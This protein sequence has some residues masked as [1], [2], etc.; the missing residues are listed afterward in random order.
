VQVD[1]APAW[2]NELV[3]IHGEPMG[4]GEIGTEGAGAAGDGS[5][6]D[7]VTGRLRACGDDEVV[8]DAD[9]LY[10]LA[11]YGLANLAHAHL[12]A[13]GDLQRGTV[14]DGEGDGAR[15]SRHAGTIHLQQMGEFSY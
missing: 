5:H 6:G 10:D 2:Q 14:R 12:S 1:G 7:D 3:E 9:S 4:R 8:E 15:R 11:V 13:K